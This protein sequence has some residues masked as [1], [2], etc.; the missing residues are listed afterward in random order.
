MNGNFLNASK[1]EYVPHSPSG[2]YSEYLYSTWDT[3]TTAWKVQYKENL[4]Y[5]AGS[6]WTEYIQQEPNASGVLE[7]DRRT[8]RTYNSKDKLTSENSYVWENGAWRNQNQRHFTFIADTLLTLDS[9]MSWNAS[10]NLW[11]NQNKTVQTYNA[12]GLL[13]SYASYSWNLTQNAWVG[14]SKYNL[15]YNAQRFV[16]EQ[17]D[18]I[19]SSTNNA[20]IELSKTRF[21]RNVNGKSLIDSVLSWWASGPNPGMGSYGNPFRMR[22]YTYNTNDVLV[23]FR[24]DE[25]NLSTGGVTSSNSSNI[26]LNS[27][28]KPLIILDQD[29][30]SVAGG[31]WRPIRKWTYTYN[32]NNDPLTEIYEQRI[33]GDSLTNISKKTRTYNTSN[34]LLTY[35]DETWNN[36]TG[37]WVGLFGSSSEYNP[38]GKI[39]A[40]ESKSGWIET[41]NYFIN[42]FRTEYICKTAPVGVREVAQHKLKVYPNPVSRGNALNIEV[43]QDG[44][45]VLFDFYGRIVKSGEI[46][47]GQNSIYTTDLST[48]LYILKMN[49][50]SLKLVV[51]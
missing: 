11:E 29:S 35:L 47:V 38:E 34:L 50:S 43:L 6:N 23:T 28:D 12:Q 20:F 27:A 10:T 15:N 16:Y 46:S 36:T 30:S 51:Q 32:S 41:G 44:N 4:I 14:T 33:T 3:V 19:W 39:I 2:S 8:I 18:F 40:R 25:L 1:E 24:Q 45:Y 21:T 31:V 9:S 13:T 48:G 49:N 37:A 22:Y 17:E 5:G 42:H 26:T 7:N